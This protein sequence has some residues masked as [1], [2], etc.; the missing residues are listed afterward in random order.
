MNS[1]RNLLPALC[2]FVII[3]GCVN[4]GG[5]GTKPLEKHFFT[6]NPERLPGDGNTFT[7]LTAKVHRFQ[8]SPGYAGREIV[9][10][11]PEGRVQSDYYHNYFI[12]P[13]E[14]LTTSLYGWLN[15]S[16][17]FKHTISPGSLAPSDISIEGVINGLYGDYS[18]GSPKAVVRMQF[19]VLD[20]TRSG[21]PIL[22]NRDYERTINVMNDEVATMIAAMEQGCREIFESFEAD[23]RQGLAGN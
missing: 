23:M 3:T 10:H 14:M 20:E 17:L 8:I 12:A 15:R 5:G 9:Y 2:L 11:Y 19:F 7:A 13:D 21:T 18:D 1:L 16:G 4:V 6:I 22:F